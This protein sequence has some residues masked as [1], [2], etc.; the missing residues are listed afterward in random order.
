LKSGGD[1]FDLKVTKYTNSQNPVNDRDFWPNDPVQQSLQ[2]Y[3]FATSFWYEK[4]EGEFKEVPEH[5]DKIANFY[6]GA[7]YWAFCH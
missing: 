6:F 4:R 2:N 3:F 5:V 1:E 7:A